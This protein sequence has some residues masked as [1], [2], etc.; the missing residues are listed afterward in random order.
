MPFHW[1]SLWIH[2]DSLQQVL[3]RYGGAMSVQMGGRTVG[4]PLL[5]MWSRDSDLRAG[6]LALAAFLQYKV[7]SMLSAAGSLSSASDGWRHLQ[8]MCIGETLC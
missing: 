3:E 1:Q 6:C 4:V 2:P 8:G 7:Q 5:A